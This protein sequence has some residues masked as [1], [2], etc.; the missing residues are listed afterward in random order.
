MSKIYL[1]EATR[2]NSRGTFIFGVPRGEAPK[3]KPLTQH[4]FKGAGSEWLS[5]AAGGGVWIE[6]CQTA[7]LAARITL[8]G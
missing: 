5:G 3:R 1:S 7:E 8:P 4:L 6:M 2:F